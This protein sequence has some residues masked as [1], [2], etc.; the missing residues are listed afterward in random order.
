MRHAG[1]DW[2]GKSSESQATATRVEETSLC[3]HPYA[4]SLPAQAT[5]AAIWELA[6]R[7]LGS[8]RVSGV[9]ETVARNQLG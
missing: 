3:A 5:R 9:G 1:A 4:H 2:E 6:R 7:P 8:A